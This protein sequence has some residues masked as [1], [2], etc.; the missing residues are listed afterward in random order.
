MLV[1]D[2]R[3]SLALSPREAGTRSKWRGPT[4]P[5]SITVSPQGHWEY[6]WLTEGLEGARALIH[7]SHGCSVHSTNVN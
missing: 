6:L 5:G 1:L 4:H 3:A 2:P 7:L